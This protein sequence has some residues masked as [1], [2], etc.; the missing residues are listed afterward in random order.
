MPIKLDIQLLT[1]WLVSKR[2]PWHV[3]FWSF[4]G[5]TKAVSYYATIVYYDPLFLEFMLISEVAFVALVYATL[6][7]YTYFYSREK[8]GYYFFT[9]LVIWGVYVYLLVIFQ[10]NYLQEIRDI[11]NL[12]HFDI[13]LNSIT[14]Y[15][16]SFIL[17][18]M[19]KYFKDNFIRQFYENAREKLQIQFELQNLKAQISPHFLFNTMNNFYGLAVEQSTKLPLLMVRLSELLRYSLYETTSAQVPLAH[20]ITYLENYIELE[21]IRLEDS[22]EFEFKAHVGHAAQLEIAPL[23]FIVFAENA[24]KHAKNVEDDFTKIAIEISVSQA[25]VLTFTVT[26]NC[27]QNPENIDYNKRGV[28]LENVRKRLNVLYPEPLHKLNIEKNKNYFQVELCIHLKNK[29]NEQ[30]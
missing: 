10:K 21:K 23:I 29:N 12:R 27:L 15:F 1:R 17:L 28:G 6:R 19:A 26:N 20:E 18:T 5:T 9:G 14:S 25:D 11:A 2:W 4:Y 13:F 22:L 8:Y 30:R 24:F 16:I 3:A 7:L